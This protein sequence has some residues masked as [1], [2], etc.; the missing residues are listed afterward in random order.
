M[1]ER[2]AKEAK[3]AGIAESL[4]SDPE[5][6]Q[7]DSLRTCA[8][9]FPCRLITDASIIER[10]PALFFLG[11]ISPIFARFF[12]VFSPFFRCFLRRDARI[13]ESGSKRPGAGCVTVENGRGK[14][15]RRRPI[16]GG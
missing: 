16:L 5:E 12:A 4:P 3:A 8:L 10:Q 6:E 1:A 14:S 7:V 15:G 9:P 2:A 13:P 11:H